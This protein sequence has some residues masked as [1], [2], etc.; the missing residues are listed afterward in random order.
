MAETNARKQEQIAQL[1]VELQAA[2]DIAAQQTALVATLRLDLDQARQRPSTAT[3]ATDHEIV[4][5]MAKKYKIQLEISHEKQAQIDR[6]QDDVAA[7]HR[8]VQE[9]EDSTLAVRNELAQAQASFAMAQSDL[10]QE[11]DRVAAMRAKHHADMAGLRH[12]HDLAVHQAAQDADRWK[13]Q[14][15]KWEDR[16]KALELARDALAE[17]LDR[18]EADQKLNSQTVQDMQRESQHLQLLRRKSCGDLADLTQ[19]YDKLLQQLAA[20]QKEKESLQQDQRT[21]EATLERMASELKLHHNQVD[22]LE[23]AVLALKMDKTS[24][25]DKLRQL[26]RT[27]AATLQTAADTHGELKE[28]MEKLTMAQNQVMKQRSQVHTL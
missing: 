18:A 3:A 25:E 20:L 14:E 6:L 19:K 10:Q 5:D 26:E 16:A 12:A 24:L 1:E 15:K 23:Q 28:H 13:A 22:A 4:D 7:A 11:L 27:H 8:S 9:S 17:R 2:N 21:A